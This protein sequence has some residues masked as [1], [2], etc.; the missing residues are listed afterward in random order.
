MPKRPSPFERQ[1][2]LIREIRATAPPTAAAELRAC[3]SS[4]EPYIVGF[5][6][7]AIAELTLRACVPD[8]A[9]A[10]GRMIRGEQ[11]DTGCAG[12]EKVARALVQLDADEPD[13]Y[14]AGLGYF[15]PERAGPGPL[16]DRA[17]PVRIECAIGLARAVAPRA[18]VEIAPL[19]VDP[20]P[21]VRAGAARAIAVLPGDGPPAVLHLTLVSREK[22]PDVL[23]A[24]MSGLL[25]IDAARYLPIVERHLADEATAEVAAIALGESR[26]ADAL[27]VLR[28][29]LAARRPDDIT[30]V[31]LLAAALL[32]LPE[33]TELLFETLESGSEALAVQ[34]LEALAVH[35]HASA[36]DARVRAIV[37]QRGSSKIARALAELFDA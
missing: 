15:R 24:C 17:V 11:P 32:R 10:L 22:D 20:E 25:A 29:A 4:R 1:L 18:L 33:A 12:S 35:R 8:L 6:A 34:A 37:A 7:E 5:A 3:L 21:P 28:R 26:L 16:V 23:G 14:R 9:S 13:A 2:A 30:A 19:L 27:P 36:V 31:I